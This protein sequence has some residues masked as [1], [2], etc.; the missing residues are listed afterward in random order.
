LVHRDT[1]SQDRVGVRRALPTEI[2]PLASA[3]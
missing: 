2:N 1:E 3:L